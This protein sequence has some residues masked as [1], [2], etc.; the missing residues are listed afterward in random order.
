[1]EGSLVVQG[2]RAIPR[3][4]HGTFRVS[5]PELRFTTDDADLPNRMR[6]TM[7][8]LGF[9]STVT[10]G[11]RVNL[12]K[13]NDLST[14]FDRADKLKPQ[15]SWF[16]RLIGKHVQP[17]PQI[18]GALVAQGMI[19]IDP[20]R[21]VDE[22]DNL[23]PLKSLLDHLDYDLYA[24]TVR[25]PL[26][27]R[28]LFKGTLSGFVRLSNTPDV[29]H[30]PLLTGVLY[31][32][33]A[34]LMYGELSASGGK[35]A[36]PFNPALSVALQ[37]G[38]NDVF[39]LGK[40]SSASRII[41]P[42]FA[43]T[44]T[45]LFPPFSQAD[46]SFA[47]SGALA[48]PAVERN[49]PAYRYTA[50]T[51]QEDYGTHGSITGTLLKPIIQAD[52]MLNAAESQILLPGGILNIEEG[53]GTIRYSSDEAEPLHF[54]VTHGSATGTLYAA[55]IQNEYQISAEINNSDLLQLNGQMP[56]HF[57]T[58]SAPTGALP[59]DDKDIAMHL[60]GASDLADVLGGKQPILTPL[61]TL[62][63]NY[64]VKGMF[65]K[66]ARYLGLQTFHADITPGQTP[67]ATLTTQEFGQTRW[68]AFRLGT[69]SVLS[70]P[71]TWKIWLN[72]RLPDARFLRN[73]SMTLQTDQVQN[74]T[75][76]IRYQWAF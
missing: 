65:A 35:F 37:V 6:E 49:H 25:T 56:F 67:G 24:K 41:Q 26:R 29:Q 63:Q 3:A 9:S 2:T 18:Q 64:Y 71:T 20:K 38:A 46:Q 12:V 11:R 61:Y 16:D 22:R 51:L 76:T 62:G 17:P 4:D 34:Q 74:N 58:V 1:M 15:V 19:Q 43:F 73:L 44:P 42:E 55:G 72:Y 14:I 54:Y 31:L 75:F 57:T 10:N 33:Q 23:L 40:N 47:Q 32:E 68:S 7:L 21:I 36:I 69:T 53:R 48:K 30:Q 66:W 45:R 70:N 50:S 8:D 13:V 59:L 39:T 60:L 28:D 27:W 5:A 52:F